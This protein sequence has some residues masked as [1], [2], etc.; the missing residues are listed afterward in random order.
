MDSSRLHLC[1]R[2]MSILNLRCENNYTL[3]PTSPSSESLNVGV[4]PGTLTE[5]YITGLL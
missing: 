4:I 3:T 5:A 2:I 1:I